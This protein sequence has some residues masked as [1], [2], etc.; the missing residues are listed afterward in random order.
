MRNETPSGA[1]I[2]L[3]LLLLQKQSHHPPKDEGR[4]ATHNVRH[5]NSSHFC[6]TASLRSPTNQPTNQPK[7]PHRRNRVWSETA[8]HQQ[9]IR[10]SLKITF[11][12]RASKPWRIISV[13]W[14]LSTSF[15]KQMILDRAARAP[16]N[17]QGRQHPVFLWRKI[18]VVRPPSLQL[19]RC[20]INAKP[21]PKP[22]W[23]P[24][25]L[26]MEKIRATL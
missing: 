4:G 21:F 7:H 10:D 24:L 1:I 25:C 5:L 2:L 19:T 6:P 3:L 16:I 18:I 17:C 26:Q 9:K 23:P 13:P 20:A 22:S 14:L 15:I 8:C 11:H 12:R